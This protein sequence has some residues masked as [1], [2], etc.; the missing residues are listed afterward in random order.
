MSESKAIDISILD[1]KNS[2][3]ISYSHAYALLLTQAGKNFGPYTN[4]E[5][6]NKLIVPYSVIKKAKDAKNM[7]AKEIYILS[8]ERPD[9]IASI[10]SSLNLWGFS[11]YLDYIYTISELSFLEGLIPVLDVGILAPSE[12][13]KLQEI[14]GIL[15]V[16]L[17]NVTDL[18]LIKEN[19]DYYNQKQTLRL[20]MIEWAGKLNFN[21]KVYLLSQN[22]ETVDHKRQLLKK[23]AD[24]HEKYQ[25]IHEITIFPIETTKTKK[26]SDILKTIQLCKKECPTINVNVYPSNISV[27][28]E[29]LDAGLV[30]LSSIYCNIHP[31]FPQKPTLDLEEVDSI[32]TKKKF[33]L[34]QRFPL[35]KDFIEQSKYSDK[36]GQ[37]FDAYRYKI[38]KS[39][40]DK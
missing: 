31:C 21:V 8:G 36:L 2:D 24:L 6:E 3:T 18:N 19:P 39:Q 40:Q 34:Q 11:S 13:I 33:K 20:K 1:E 37:I 15:C 38:K 22:K 32:C 35:S 12:L 29:V 14:A 30:D 26:I 17:H 10:R 4:F 9:K 16:H 5:K 25:H 7:M 23:L 28:K 27:V